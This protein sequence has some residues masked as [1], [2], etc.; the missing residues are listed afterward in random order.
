[1]GDDRVVSALEDG[2]YDA[3]VVDADSIDDEHARV[4]LVITSG[5]Q[6]GEV[7]GVRA[8]GLTED[9]L[10]LL[11]LPASIRVTNGQVAVQFER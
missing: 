5:P 3:L 6:K 10:A 2:T 9:P 8:S 4:E 11:G 1:V 7:V